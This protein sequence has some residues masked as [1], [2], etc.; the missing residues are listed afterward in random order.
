MP[1]PKTA[2]FNQADL[3]SEHLL[4]TFYFI[5]YRPNYIAKLN[6]S[7]KLEFLNR[8]STQHWTAHHQNCGRLLKQNKNEN[9][10]KNTKAP[11]AKPKFTPSFTPRENPSP[12]L[13]R[14]PSST[15]TNTTTSTT[16]QTTQIHRF[17][18][19]TTS[20]YDVIF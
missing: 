5:L 10:N 13:I 18:R 9:E 2:H 19:H 4:V 16:T 1:K 8:N 20:F 12:S 6:L 14:H 15:N 17:D 11:N 3:P 7:T